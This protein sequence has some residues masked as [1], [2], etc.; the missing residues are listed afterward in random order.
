M[1][2]ERL[3][4]VTLP[5]FSEGFTLDGL[6]DQVTLITAPN[7][8]GKSSLVRALKYLLKNPEGSDPLVSLAADFRDGDVHWKV[9]R[10]GSQVTWQ[11][12]G[13]TVPRPGLPLGE[14]LDRYCLSMEDLIKADQADNALAQELFR[15]LRGGFDLKSPRKL[16]GPR[17][18]NTERREF[19]E[20]RTRVR[21]AETESE[22]LHKSEKSLPELNA[23][24][25]EARAAQEQVRRI[26]KAKELLE[27]TRD[28]S[29][30]R[31]EFA[32]FP[33]D[34]DKLTGNEIRRLDELHQRLDKSEAEK[35]EQSESKRHAQ[36]RL[37]AAG[38]EEKDLDKAGIDL[39]A[40]RAKL[41]KAG[42]LQ[43]D[44]ERLWEVQAEKTTA[45]DVAAQS[46]GGPSPPELNF[47]NLSR[48]EHL[49]R[50][51]LALRTKQQEGK[52][53]I[54][55]QADAPRESEIDKHRDATKA[56]QEWLAGPSPSPST[57]KTTRSLWILAALLIIV[58]ASLVFTPPII[59]LTL[60]V[61]PLAVIG[62]II[63]K[64][65]G[66]ADS[67]SGKSKD[68]AQLRFEALGFGPPRWDADAVHT[69]LIELL[70]RQYELILQRRSSER[71]EDLRAE[72]RQVEDDL[73]KKEQ[74]CADLAKTIGF[75]PLTP[76]TALDRFLGLAQEWD[77]ARKDLD[78]CNRTL[79]ARREEV[80]QATADA[81]ELLAP[82]LP[83]SM[84]LDASD[85]DGLNAVCEELD[86]R[87]AEGV[88]AKG[89]RRLAESSIKGIEE[90]IKQHRKDIAKVYEGA[91]LEDGQR[92][93]LSDRLAQ[94]DSWKDV[95]QSLQH[96]AHS[97][98]RLK[99]EL[100][101]Q[102]D[103]IELAQNEDRVGLDELE[104]KY[105]AIASG[106]EQL[107]K[108]HGGIEDRIRRAQSEQAL[109]GVI[110]CRVDAESKLEQKRDELLLSNATDL[111]LDKVEQSFRASH[112]PE[113]L[114]RA[115][116]LFREVTS[117]QFELELA[118]EGRFEAR[119]TRRNMLLGLHA[120][121]TGTRMQLLLAVRLAWIQT[122]SEEAKTLP[123]FLD[124]ALTTSDEQRF[125]LIAKS[126]L[127][128][129]ASSGVQVIYLSA[130]DHE[131]RL[132]KDAIGENLHTI[133]LL[134]QRG[135]ASSKQISTFEI[136][137]REPI[138][139]PG[140]DVLAYAKVI[141]VPPIDPRL[142]HREIHVFHLLRDDLSLLYRVMEQL[143]FTRLGQLESY[144]QHKAKG[145]DSEEWHSR[146][147]RR[148]AAAESWV[149][150]WLRGRGKPIGVLELEGSDAF[151]GVFMTAASALV[152]SQEING[153]TQAM[154]D[155]L[156]EGSLKRFHSSKID[157]FALWLKEN[158]YLDDQPVLS[159]D[160][161]RQAVLRQYD[162][163][164]SG[165]LADIN[166][167]ID[168][169]EAG[170][171]QDSTSQPNRSEQ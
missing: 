23:E 117:N 110:A 109:E 148:C 74:D 114:Q 90:A 106:H 164:E 166:Q 84:D 49:A 122:Q 124:E 78:L 22:A 5:G 46:L 105:Q 135:Q 77:T 10:K 153:D 7:A 51:M 37:E 132:W 9:E 133:D 102:L 160:E 54:E 57:F 8:S 14:E 50:E 155:A 3:E 131:R 81:R 139:E 134:R 95:R 159:T 45:R 38:L 119:D 86:K 52:L 58:G 63:W 89:D 79:V 169:L 68:D 123:V 76:L 151:S 88:A 143:R 42:E 104:S 92:Q 67:N 171:A 24:I 83:R 70:Q 144:L 146:L 165:A 41:R 167:C 44:V 115:G 25:E 85:F 27:A 100:K 71:A 35:R 156:R 87:I 47:E 127:Q 94:L 130:R 96:V 30:H 34:M 125:A 13:A 112:E 142:G 145:A 11:R 72:L 61:L 56:L 150:E 121:S 107:L 128:L 48:A 55:L 99:N 93:V 17:H 149:S 80:D 6:S 65:R 53:K 154:L 113:V 168:W 29:A 60:L 59:A 161:R 137:S 62:W 82:W 66:W 158:E 15:S 129:S 28:H 138:P 101:D 26:K 64:L 21:V 4:I 33:K 170:L 147:L 1:K 16:L 141:Q 108:E 116:T 69:R 20:A 12:N 111:L 118:E 31:D 40:G 120:L 97:E 75:D 163:E 140:T 43:R 36:S 103:L 98:E 136:A 91:G 39:K 73:R 2:L 162:F 32:S 19:N 152:L 18:G 157:K 126:L